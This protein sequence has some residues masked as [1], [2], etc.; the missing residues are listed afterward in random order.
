MYPFDRTER[1][2]LEDR[3]A[4]LLGDGDYST[5]TT[6]E[7]RRALVDLRS[8]PAPKPQAPIPASRPSPLAWSAPDY[9]VRDGVLMA[10][11]VAT[12]HTGRVHLRD[13]RAPQRVIWEGRSMTASSLRRYLMTGS[14][15][16][17]PAKPFRA[18]VWDGVR[19]RHLGYFATVEERDAVVLTWRFTR[20]SPRYTA[21]T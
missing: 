19:A 17:S 15:E 11:R 8:V 2:D 18:V 13:T 10:R 20:V 1:D 21:Q 3:V 12:D 6:A 4:R 14:W 16:K 9:F 7:L 5:W